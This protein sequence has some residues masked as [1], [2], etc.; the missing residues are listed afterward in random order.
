MEQKWHWIGELRLTKWTGLSSELFTYKTAK[1]RRA[2]IRQS[3]QSKCRAYIK[4]SN[5]VGHT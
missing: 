5:G 4:Q 1:W 2:H 3:R